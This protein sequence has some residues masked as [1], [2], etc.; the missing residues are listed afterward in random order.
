[1]H[2]I[3][4]I[5]RRPLVDEQP[6][7][8]TDAEGDSRSHHQGYGRADDLQPVGLQECR[9]TAQLTEVAAARA[10]FQG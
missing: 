3:E 1:M 6:Q 9:G 4:D 5:Q 8:L 10:I 7:A 2:P